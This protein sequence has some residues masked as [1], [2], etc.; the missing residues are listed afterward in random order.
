MA[1]KAELD[2]V[3]TK[4]EWTR[5][6]VSDEIG[7]FN[8]IFGDNMVGFGTGGQA[9]IRGLTNAYGVPTKLFP[10]NNWGSYFDDINYT[11]NCVAI[12]EA[13]AKIP[14]DLPV[15]VNVNI[16]KGLAMLN[17]QAPMTYEYLCERLGISNGTSFAQREESSPPFETKI[18]KL[19]M[20]LAAEARPRK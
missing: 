4:D 17:K 6:D 13:I 18:G 1:D 15:V 3:Y 11:S 10:N 9:C 12:D 20:I 8:F 19:R 14:N 5:Q 2:F 16:G 7:K